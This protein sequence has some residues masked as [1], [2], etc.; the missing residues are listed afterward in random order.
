MIGALQ[1]AFGNI[2]T[3]LYLTP[4]I[5]VYCTI[6]C[7]TRIFETLGSH[8]KINRGHN[9]AMGPSSLNDTLWKFGYA[10]VH[11]NREY[12]CALK[13]FE[14]QDLFL[15]PPPPGGMI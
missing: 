11:H 4:S 8:I 3:L 7:I 1:P 14:L 10:K 6:P 9:T 2:S 15:T 5:Q 13:R 12:I